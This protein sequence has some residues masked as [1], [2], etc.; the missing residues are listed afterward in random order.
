[1]LNTQDDRRWNQGLPDLP[2]F[3][4]RCLEPPVHHEV[5]MAIAS[6]ESS[7]PPHVNKTSQE[8]TKQLFK[9]DQK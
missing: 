9:S 6:L 7:I 2:V 4:Q 3:L 5:I 8:I 1:M